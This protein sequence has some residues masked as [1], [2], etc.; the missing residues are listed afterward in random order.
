MSQIEKFIIRSIPK[1]QTKEWFKYKHY[2]KRIPSIRY[3]F[4]LYDGDELIGVYI[5]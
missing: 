3:S 2:A 5:W 1:E 4:G